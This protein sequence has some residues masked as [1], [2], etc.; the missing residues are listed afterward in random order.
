MRVGGSR[1]GGGFPVTLRLTLKDGVSAGGAEK[2]LGAPYPGSEVVNARS[3]KKF[4]S[5]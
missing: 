3:G 1:E 5:A 2:P 4:G